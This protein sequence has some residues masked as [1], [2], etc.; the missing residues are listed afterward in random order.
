M[1][2]RLSMAAAATGVLLLASATGAFQDIRKG[3]AN[4]VEYMTGGIG[5]E[6]R[7]A[8]EELATGYTLKLVFALTSGN[9]LSGVRVT[10]LKSTGEHALEAVTNGPWLYAKLPEGQYTLK[11]AHQ[12]QEQTRSLEVGKGLRVATIHWA[13]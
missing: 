10:I 4:G 12:G 9:Y 11:A 3:T 7:Q 5:Q 8:M 1:K 2:P 6:E 13:P